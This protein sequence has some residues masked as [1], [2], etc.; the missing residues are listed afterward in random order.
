MHFGKLIEA[1]ISKCLIEWT[2][3]NNIIGNF[4][5]GGRQGYSTLTAILNIQNA[6]DYNL[7][8][9]QFN[10]LFTTD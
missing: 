4:H 2:N 3:A 1:W 8:Y 10:V 9:N 7:F 6:I 5:H